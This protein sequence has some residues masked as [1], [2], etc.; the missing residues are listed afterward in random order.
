MGFPIWAG[1]QLP[2]GGLGGFIARRGGYAKAIAYVEGIP[3][4]PV[5]HL[6][7][8]LYS[9][10]LQW[11]LDRE[12][13]TQADSDWSVLFPAL[14]LVV[15]G[16]HTSLYWVKRL[17]NP[18]DPFSQIELVGRTRDDAA[19]EAFDKVSKLLCL[20]Y[21]GGPIIDQ[22]AVRGTLSGLSFPRPGSPPAD[23]TSAS[24]E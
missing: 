19:G 11:S 14:C 9:A 23:S 5:N 20:G 1:L 17:G 21:P 2:R 18:A 8:H 24:Q 15:S 6:E 3:I 7:G 12:P 16:G 10:P 22:L 4:A 13:E